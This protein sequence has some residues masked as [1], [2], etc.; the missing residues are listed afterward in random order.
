LKISVDIPGGFDRIRYKQEKGTIMMTK[1][2]QEK[3]FQ[4][5]KKFW[6]KP[7]NMAILK[8]MAKK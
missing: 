6:S 5:M 3:A 7:E 1:E 2:Q 4:R 8:R